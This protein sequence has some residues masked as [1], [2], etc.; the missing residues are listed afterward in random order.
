MTAFHL[1]VGAD[2]LATLTFDAVGVGVGAFSPSLNALG[3]QL[4]LPLTAEW[5]G[6]SAAVVPEP[7]GALLFS[8]GFAVVA[9]ALARR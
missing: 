4:G 9:V 3:D 5:V 2:R 1:E 7:G 6:A 8:M